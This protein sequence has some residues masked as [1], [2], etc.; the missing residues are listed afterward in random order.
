MKTFGLLLACAFALSGCVGSTPSDADQQKLV[1]DWSPENV[2]KA[3]EAKGM[4]KEADEVR[5]N[6]ANGGEQG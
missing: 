5:R 3:Y 4:Q 6:A 1:K 2:A